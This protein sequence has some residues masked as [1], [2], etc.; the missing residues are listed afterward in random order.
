MNKNKIKICF[1]KW[2]NVP[3]KTIALWFLLVEMFA[4]M[5]EFVRLK[6]IKQGMATLL[7]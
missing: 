4:S 6:K 7:R 1:L 5:N 3:K 2:K